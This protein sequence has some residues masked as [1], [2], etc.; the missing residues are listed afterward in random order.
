M[1]SYPKVISVKAC[2]VILVLWKAEQGTKKIKSKWIVF[3][4]SSHF[5]QWNMN[6]GIT[7]GLESWN[8]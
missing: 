2:S 5:T 4:F 1:F 7:A 6:Y 3:A 8:S